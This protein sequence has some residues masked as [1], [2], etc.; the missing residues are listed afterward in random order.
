MQQKTIET[1]WEALKPGECFFVPCVDELQAKKIGLS[2]GYHSQKEAPVAVVG[3]YRGLW[4]VMFYRE[5]GYR[6]VY[7]LR[8]PGRVRMRPS[9]EQRLS[10]QHALDPAR[11]FSDLK[12]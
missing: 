10:S 12:T 7:P 8:P 2:K 3:I 6:R 5:G 9:D 1:A 11:L 4:G